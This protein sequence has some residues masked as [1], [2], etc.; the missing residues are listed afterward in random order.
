M[1]PRVDSADDARQAVAAMR[2]PPLGVRGVAFSNRVCHYG[3][4]FK[5]YLQAS[6]DAL[7]TIVQIETRSAVEAVDEIAAVDGVDVLFIGPS[8]LSHSYGILG[9]FDHPDFVNALHRTRDAALRHHK[10]LGILLPSPNDLHY[11]KD[12][13]F[14]LL[15]SG[16]DA[17]LLNNA[18][19]ALVQ[20]LR[21]NL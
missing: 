14:R 13:G 6:A 15:A 20:G 19:R 11:Y 4:N 17:V 12:L 10:H 7:L 1:F 5:P 3:S 18:A 21:A 9:Q 2:Y 16:S 8:D